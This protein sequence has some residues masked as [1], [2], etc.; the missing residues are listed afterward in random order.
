MILSTEVEEDLKNLS[1]I[2]LLN[3]RSIPHQDKYF[4]VAPMGIIINDHNP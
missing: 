3:H 2:F 1:E 4:K